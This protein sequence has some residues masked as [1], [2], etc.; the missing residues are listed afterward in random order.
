MSLNKV[1]GYAISFIASII[2]NAIKEATEIIKEEESMDYYALPCPH[3]DEWIIILKNEV[4]CR[5]FRHGT[6]KK[7][8][9]QIPPHLG[10]NQ[11]DKLAKNGEIYGCGKP[12]RLNSKN[13]AE[14]CGYI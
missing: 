14:I 2:K 10:K 13:K 6:Y 5:I 12:F 8:Y 7:N 9:Q 4:A 3:C 1:N 11:C